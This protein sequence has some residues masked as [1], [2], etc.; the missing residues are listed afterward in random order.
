MQNSLAAMTGINTNVIFLASKIGY[1]NFNHN[2]ITEQ[3]NR[4]VKFKFYK[5]EKQN[6]TFR[7]RKKILVLPNPIFTSLK[8]HRGESQSQ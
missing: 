8:A 2:Q 7:Y 6:L 4:V 3:Y 1:K 5:K